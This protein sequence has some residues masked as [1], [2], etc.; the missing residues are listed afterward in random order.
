MFCEI[1]DTWSL[2]FPALSI[3]WYL[4]SA[5]MD[6]MLLLPF[7]HL[8]PLLPFSAFVEFCHQWYFIWAAS[9]WGSQSVCCS[10]PSTLS[11]CPAEGLPPLSI[12]QEEK[13]TQTDINLYTHPS[14]HHHHLPSPLLRAPVPYLKCAGSCVLV[15]EKRERDRRVCV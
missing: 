3:Y 8:L 10:R 13:S 4:M 9:T 12:V 7:P 1:Y 14:D 6:G 2:Q 11:R 5:L 15:C